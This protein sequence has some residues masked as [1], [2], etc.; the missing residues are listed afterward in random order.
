MA[1]WIHHLKLSLSG[2]ITKDIPQEN[3]VGGRQSLSDFFKDWTAVNLIIRY[4][5]MLGN[6]F[7]MSSMLPM[8]FY[9]ELISRSMQEF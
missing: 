5:V 7:T 1:S 4:E 2:Y 6:F 3:G 9:W 8:H